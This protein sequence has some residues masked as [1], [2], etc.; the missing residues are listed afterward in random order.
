[1]RGKSIYIVRFKNFLFRIFLK[2]CGAAL[3]FF[4]LLSP[5]EGQSPYRVTWGAESAWIGG[6]GAGFGVGYALYARNQAFTPEQVAA[7]SISEVPKF[8]RYAVRHYSEKARRVSDVLLYSSFALPLCLL[9]DKGVRDHAA[10][11]GLIAAE[12]ILLSTSLTFLAKETAHRSRPF[13][14][15]PNVPL[16]AKLTRDAR[17]SFFSGHTSTVAAASFLTAKVWSDYHP[18]S[19]WQPAVWTAAVALPASTGFLRMQGGKHFLS[20]VV[21]GFAVGA[22]VG[23]MVPELHRP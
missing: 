5:L 8:D 22:L 16:P 21:T 9:F 6:S 15:N 12:S 23:W 17:K 10:G 2:K 13:L 18:D 3:L 1:M 7:L 19:R 11:N 20:D 14:Y 4:L